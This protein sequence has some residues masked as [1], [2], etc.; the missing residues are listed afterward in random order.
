LN[1][2]TA[3]IAAANPVFGRWNTAIS[4]ERNLGLPTALLSRFDL[5]FVLLDEPNEENDEALARH[6]TFVHMNNH[7]RTAPHRIACRLPTVIASAVL[8]RLCVR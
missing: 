6:I 2:R 8:T 3:I 4:A 5:T 7:V 1:A